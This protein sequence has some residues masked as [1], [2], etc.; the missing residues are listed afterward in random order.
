MRGDHGELRRRRI[1]VQRYAETKNASLVCRRCGIRPPT[2]RLWWK[3]FLAKGDAGLISLSRRPHHSPHRVL[4]QNR[5]ALILRLRDERKLGPTRIQAELLRHHAIRWSTATIWK[6]LH[7]H[8]R[9][10]LVR[11]RPPESPRRYSRPL[12]GDRVQVDTM[13]VSPGR[14][15]YTAIDDCTRLRV[16]GLYPRR[17]ASNAVHFLKQR[18]VEEFPFPI[19]RV[20]TDRGGE[21]SGWSFK[22]P[23]HATALSS[24]L[25]APAKS[26]VRNKP[27]GWSFTPQ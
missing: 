9:A 16:L 25:T 10:P 1:W 4:D 8:A 15:P 19:Q 7:S 21:F 18:M 14:F 20:Q 6:V 11:K 17:T 2:L 3:R 27:I 22:R 5:L 13:K 12:P 23:Y 24:G 26:S